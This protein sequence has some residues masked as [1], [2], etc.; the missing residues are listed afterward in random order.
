MA[1][2]KASDWLIRAFLGL[3]IGGC[4]VMFIGIACDPPWKLV[5]SRVGMGCISLAFGANVASAITRRRMWVKNS[6][7]TPSTMMGGAGVFGAMVFLHVVMAVICACGVAM[8]DES[9]R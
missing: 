2:R 6:V 3:W 9:W 4:V 5:V 7:E 8:M 1:K